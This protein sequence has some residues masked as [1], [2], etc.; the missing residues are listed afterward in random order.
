MIAEVL[1]DL[2]MGSRQEVPSLRAIRKLISLGHIYSLP[3]FRGRR[4]TI[5]CILPTSYDTNLVAVLDPLLASL[6]FSNSTNR[7]R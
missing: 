4:L 2:L 1:A 5:A 3:L 7:T 6:T